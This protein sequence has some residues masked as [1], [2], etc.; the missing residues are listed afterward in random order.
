MTL[1]VPTKEEYCAAVQ[2]SSFAASLMTSILYC[3]EAMMVSSFT[4]VDDKDSTGHI[5]VL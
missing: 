2:A 5:D 3:C 1:S 4:R